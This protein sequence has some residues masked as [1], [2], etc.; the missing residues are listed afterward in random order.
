[1]CRYLLLDNAPGQL[2][3]LD[4]ICAEPAVCCCKEDE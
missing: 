1:M 4:A 3:E 2:V